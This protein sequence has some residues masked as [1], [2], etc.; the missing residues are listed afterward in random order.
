MKSGDT[1]FALANRFGVGVEDLRRANG[2]RGSS[3]AA[4]QTLKIPGAASA[5]EAAAPEEQVAPRRR[6][7]RPRCAASARPSA[8]DGPARLVSAGRG[9]HGPKSNI[10]TPGKSYRPQGRDIEGIAGRLDSS[11]PNS[12]KLNKL[13]QPYRLQPGQ[14]IHG[15]AR[16]RPMWWS[17]ATRWPR[18]PSGS[19]P[20]S[21][22]RAA[23]A[24]R[25]SHGPLQP[26]GRLPRPRPMKFHAAA[27]HHVSQAFRVVDRGSVASAPAVVRHP[28]PTARPCARRTGAA[29][30]AA[31]RPAPQPAGARRS[32]RPPPARRSAT[33]RSADGPRAFVCQLVNGAT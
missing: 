24:R 18:S 17:A 13:K 33:P 7:S 23:L 5:E 26:A 3:I 25:Q 14:T 6:N 10:D 15:L 21:T 8:R 19:P 27:H 12:P 28:P 16:P 4:G 30:A 1:L 2:L 32:A 29:Q 31:R 9:R 22:L 11:S 20:P